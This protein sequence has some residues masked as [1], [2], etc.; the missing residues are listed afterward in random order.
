M[1]AARGGKVDAAKLLLA[2]GAT[3]SMQR[4]TGA[5]NP[6]LM[7][8][9]PFP[10]AAPR[11]TLV[12]F[13]DRRTRAY[14]RYH[15]KVNRLMERK[16]IQE[17]RPKD[18]N[19]GG[20]TPRHYAAREGGPSPPASRTC[21]LP[22]PIPIPKI[23]TAKLRCCFRWRTCISTR[24]P[25]CVKSGADLDKWDLLRAARPSTWRGARTS[26]RCR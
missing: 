15:G 24:T 16:I 7:W 20:F 25:C 11:P 2:A 21:W 6:A 26:A 23:R 9:K 1:A 22:T 18:M 12:T 4:K 5:A 17:P 8:A 13:L 19:K 14:E 10:R 3:T